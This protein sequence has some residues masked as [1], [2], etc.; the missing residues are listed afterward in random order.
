MANAFVVPCHGR[1]LLSGAT[2]ELRMPGA[3]IMSGTL[4]RH[5]RRWSIPCRMAPHQSSTAGT[6]YALRCSY[7]LGPLSVLRQVSSG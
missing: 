1:S 4:T 6:Q 2:R 5:R 3:N 7:F